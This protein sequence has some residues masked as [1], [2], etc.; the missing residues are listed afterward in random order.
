MIPWWFLPVSPFAFSATSHYL[1]TYEWDTQH[2]L[3]DAF[4]YLPMKKTLLLMSSRVLKLLDDCEEVFVSFESL[5]NW[6][7][8]SRSAEDW[9]LPTDSAPGQLFLVVKAIPVIPLRTWYDFSRAG[10]MAA[11][12]SVYRS[13]IG[14][15]YQQSFTWANTQWQIAPSS[16]QPLTFFKEA[17]PDRL[18]LTCYRSTEQQQQLITRIPEK[19]CRTI[20]EKSEGP[21]GWDAWLGIRSLLRTDTITHPSVHTSVRWEWYDLHKYTSCSCWGVRKM[22]KHSLGNAFL[23]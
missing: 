21:N 16:S 8:C 10:E 18:S 23:S 6:L 13:W 20:F 9:A 11:L 17:E 2:V 1:P 12:F 15:R 5:Q 7:C 4:W 22:C 14:G 3:K 19:C